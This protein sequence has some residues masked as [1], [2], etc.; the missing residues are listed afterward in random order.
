MDKKSITI[1][2]IAKEAGVSP[3][4]VS[5]VISGNAFVSGDK[6][7]RVRLAIEKYQFVPN[8]MAKGLKEQRSKVIGVIVPDIKNPYFS[9]LFYEI[10]IRAMQEDYMVFLCNT[11]DD[12]QAEL[13]MLHTL[14]NKQAEAIVIIGGALDYKDCSKD[15]IKEL[16]VLASRIPIVITTHTDQLDCI[17]VV[18]N[19]RVGMELLT[20]HLAQRGYRKIALIGGNKNVIPSTDRRR[21]FLEYVEQN[22]LL[23]EKEWMIDG[24][25]NIES[26]IALME[27][28][29]AC[30][31]KP[32]AV[33]GINDLIA[34]GA[35]KF[36]HE[37]GIKVPLDIGI[38]GCDG[39]ALGAASY[40][41]LSTV[42]TPYNHFGEKIIKTILL[43][44]QQQT[45]HRLNTIDMKLIIRQST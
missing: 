16:Q 19:E 12:N 2:D 11:D 44:L 3:A 27:K 30:D 39:I 7:E 28:L 37:R 45:Y 24:G 15:Y 36:A 33:C 25:F 9:S 4:T 1:Y 34:L 8:A 17:K 43:A 20:S 29:W 31:K 18:N 10:Q 42:A 41:A 38:A 26:G 6:A 22:G 32:D 40:P 13:K 35:L 23:T 5:R 14:V 21:Y